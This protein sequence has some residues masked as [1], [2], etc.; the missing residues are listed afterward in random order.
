METKE[1]KMMGIAK[2]LNKDMSLEEMGLIVMK[3]MSIS[4]KK[5]QINP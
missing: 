5:K 4:K 2:N 1:H 3:I